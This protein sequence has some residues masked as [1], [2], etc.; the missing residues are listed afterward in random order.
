[1][2][3]SEQDDANLDDDFDRDPDSGGGE[4]PHDDSDLLL[5]SWV[6]DL[7]A[8]FSDRA[9][10]LLPAGVEGSGEQPRVVFLIALCVV[11]EALCV[12]LVL[13]EPAVDASEIVEARLPAREALG[14]GESGEDPRDE[15]F[16]PL[17]L[18][19]PDPDDPDE[20]DAAEDRGRPGEDAVADPVWG[21]AAALVR[22]HF[23]EEVRVA[24][25]VG[26]LDDQLLIGRRCTAA[27]VAVP[28]LLVEAL[29]EREA[30]MVVPLDE[31]ADPDHVEA[32]TVTVDGLEETLHRAYV[33]G[34][35]IPVA[36][37]AGSEAVRERL[38]AA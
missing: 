33:G 11:D 5:S 26:E 9:P 28:R 34:R 35:R 25:R 29:Q 2:R 38:G 6:L 10:L 14:E 36:G 4:G 27:V 8:Q 15:W 17:D 30:V 23:T 1:M 13:D 12:S 7:R 21:A 16:A 22:E 37:L 18:F 31:L 24:L 19:A 32:E 3:A 20:A